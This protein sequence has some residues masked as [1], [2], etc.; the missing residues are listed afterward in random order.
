[1][2]YNAGDMKDYDIQSEVISFGNGVRVHEARRMDDGSRALVVRFPGAKAAGHVLSASGRLA[3]SL[4]AERQ[5]LPL[6]DVFADDENDAFCAAYQWHHSLTPLADIAPE[7]R[8]AWIM[9]DSVRILESFY[10]RR[11]SGQFVGK[12]AIFVDEQNYAVRLAFIGLAIGAALDFQSRCL[13]DSRCG[14]AATG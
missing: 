8:G 11:L 5:L 4:R 2:R 12:Q 10:L 7:V 13:G 9:R 1:M 14:T 3:M 6:A